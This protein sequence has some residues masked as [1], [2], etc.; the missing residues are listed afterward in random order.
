MSG[1]YDSMMKCIIVGDSDTGK[2]CILHR[3]TQGKFLEDLTHTIGVEF[4]AKIVEVMGKT[5]KLQVCLKKKSY[6]FFFFFFYHDFFKKKKKKT[7]HR[8]GI[9][10]DRRDTEV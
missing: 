3:F 7:H 10:Q 6:L 4:G 2:S 9:L 8:Y 1:K 5:I